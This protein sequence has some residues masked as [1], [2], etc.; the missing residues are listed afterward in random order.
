[1]SAIAKL[2]LALDRSAA[3]LRQRAVQVDDH[4]I[5]Y[6]EGGRG[7]T[8]LLLHGFGAEGSSWNRMA[9]FLTRRYHV[10]APDLPGWGS[11]TRLTSASYAYPVQVE[12]VHRFVQERKLEHFHLVGHSM[13]GGI[14]A[15]YAAK[16]P[17]EVTTLGLVAAHGIM[18]PQES[19]LRRAVA[20]GENW[21]LVSSPQDFQRLMDHLFVERPYA[22]RVVVKYLERQAISKCEQNRRIFDSLQLNDPPLAALLPKIRA[23]TLVL[24][25]EKDELIDV[26][27][28]EIFKSGINRAQ[29]LVLPN[30]G[31]MPLVD[32]G[33]QCAEAYLAF[34]GDQ[35]KSQEN[36]SGVPSRPA[37]AAS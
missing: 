27:A 12:R 6:A 21:L 34:L 20:R 1:M 19:G 31:H 29:A 37:Q 25:G 33:R 7:E 15:R 30:T 8:I 10:I 24:W 9:K 13:G 11:S 36:V 18:E 16:Y 32:H 22:P 17:D 3:G 35:M 28:V 26:S 2:L 14:A 23:A 4:R 5:L